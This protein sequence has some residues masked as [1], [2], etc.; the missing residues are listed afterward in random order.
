VLVVCHV[1]HPLRDRSDARP[2][3]EDFGALGSVKQHA[4]VV[5]GLYREELY[6]PDAD[7]EGAAELHVLKNRGGTSGY[8]DL[9]FY[10]RWLRFEDVN[11]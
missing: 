8:A 1:G 3:L 11:E 9:Y 7:V 4:D 6:T 2:T 5:L 10:R